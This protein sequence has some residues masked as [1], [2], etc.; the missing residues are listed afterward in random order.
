[1]RID[2]LSGATALR[3]NGARAAGGEAITTTGKQFLDLPVQ[4]TTDAQLVARSKDGDV[5]AFGELVQ[6]HQRA[7]YGI[8]S[9]MVADR[10]DVDDLVQEVFV[11]AF[12]SMQAFK[13]EAAFSTWVYRIAVNTTV[14]HM[15]KTKIRKAASI[16][17]PVTGLAESLVSSNGDGPETAAERLERTTAVRSALEKLPEKHRAVVV[18]HY[19]QNVGCDEIARI[20]G[21]SVGTVWPRKWNWSRTCVWATAFRPRT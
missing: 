11:Q 12:R 16:D 9:R 13:G 6:R 8:V 17:D 2:L 20:T 4:D 14:K 1:M 5:G 19:F 18:L 3:T 10:D 7:I 15:R 21:C